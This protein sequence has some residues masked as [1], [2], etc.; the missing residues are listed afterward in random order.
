M[1]DLVLL[2]RVQALSAVFVFGGSIIQDARTKEWR[3][4]RGA[5]AD[6]VGP[7]PSIER[8][9]AAWALYS[10]AKG[11]SFF[12]ILSGAGKVSSLM[13]RELIVRGVPKK[14]LIEESQSSSTQEQLRS[15]TVIAQRW[16]WQP[17]KIGILAPWWHLPRIAAMMLNRGP[18]VYPFALGKTALLAVER[19]LYAHDVK[20]W[21]PY[22]YHL[23]ASMM[24]RYMREL[25]G[26]AQLLAG[27]NDGQPYSTFDDPLAS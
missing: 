11:A 22:F 1:S 19:I 8:V 20:R 12:F 14:R 26:V 24:F 17:E 15:C 21:K 9:E 25:R 3:L 16:Q 2:N 23:E 4:L 7:C 13:A 10:M 18:E 5:E 27:S 6:N